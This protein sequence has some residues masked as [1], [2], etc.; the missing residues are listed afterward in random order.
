VLG[1]TTEPGRWSVLLASTGP[2]DQVVR[3]TVALYTAAG[4]SGT[5]PAELRRG[6]YQVSVTAENRDHTDPAAA[7]L[8]VIVVRG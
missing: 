2:A 6:A 5:S 1:V 4:F 8:T 7:D 3:S